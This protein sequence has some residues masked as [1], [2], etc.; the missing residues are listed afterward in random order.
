V[1]YVS[2]ATADTTQT[3]YHVAIIYTVN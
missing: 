3:W 1:L 2:A